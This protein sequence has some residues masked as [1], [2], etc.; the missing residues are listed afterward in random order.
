MV[1]L[2]NAMLCPVA[3]CV[4]VVL[5]FLLCM[6]ATASLLP[7]TFHTPPARL[8]HTQLTHY[9]VHYTEHCTLYTILSHLQWLQVDSNHNSTLFHRHATQRSPTHNLLSIEPYASTRCDNTK[10]GACTLVISITLSSLQRRDPPW[11]LQNTWTREGLNLQ[12]RGA[13]H[14]NGS[15]Q[16]ETFDVIDHCLVPKTAPNTF[17][18]ESQLQLAS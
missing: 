6:P 16:P 9:T 7:P 14:A 15:L 10:L 17:L 11:P 5:V 13:L 2:G 1:C 12:R 18:K 8:T 3:L 4:C